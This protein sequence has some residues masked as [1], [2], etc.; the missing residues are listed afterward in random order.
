[1]LSCPRGSINLPWCILQATLSLTSLP[2]LSINNK[3]KEK[4]FLEKGW[5][6]NLT[7]GHDGGS[8]YGHYHLNTQVLSGPARRLS[9]R[10]T[11]VLFHM[12]RPYL[13]YALKNPDDKKGAPHYVSSVKLPNERRASLSLIMWVFFTFNLTNE[14]PRPFV[15]RYGI[16]QL[17]FSCLVFPSSTWREK[18][19][20][21]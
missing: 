10:M 8:P 19:S 14:A 11:S 6:W 18:R 15:I 13:L 2:N 1:M 12:R 9:P 5:V 21:C 4:N 17:C 16:I 7:C 3:L 20:V